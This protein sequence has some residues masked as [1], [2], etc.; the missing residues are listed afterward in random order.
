MSTGRSFIPKMIRDKLQAPELKAKMRNFKNGLLDYSEGEVCVRN[1]TCNSAEIPSHHVFSQVQR[2][3]RTAEWPLLMDIVEKRLETKSNAY[4]PYKSLLLIEFLLLETRGQDHEA[5]FKGVALQ[6][7][8]R[9]EE[10]RHFQLTDNGQDVGS[11]VRQVAQ[12]IVTLVRD[13]QHTRDEAAVGS[14][15]D[16]PPRSLRDAPARR[17]KRKT[18]EMI[19]GDLAPDLSE[20]MRQERRLSVD[21]PPVKPNAPVDIAGSLETPTAVRDPSTPESGVAHKPAMDI[22]L[23]GPAE[24]LASVPPSFPS[25]QEQTTNK[26]LIPPPPASGPRRTR[27]VVVAPGADKP[28]ALIDL[29]S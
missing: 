22:D 3:L 21:A 18:A 17:S 24:T 8:H 16:A 2:Y 7:M 4:H 13:E 1:A 10:C 20:G 26:G 19:E 23:L 28:G 12:R 5:I 29:L 9:I 6:N 15:V 11:L 25:P 27:P 14:L